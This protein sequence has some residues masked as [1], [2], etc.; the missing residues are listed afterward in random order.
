MTTTMRIDNDL[1]RESELV[2]QDIGL[3]MTN[4][5]TLFLRQVAKL[6]GIPFPL[7]CNPPQVRNDYIETSRRELLERGRKAEAFFHEAR[8]NCERD[9][10]LDEINDLIRET[11]E[12]RKD[13]SQDT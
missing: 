5:V 2:F 9:W 1:K 3:N 10:S 7:M 11:R 8:E 6:R 4:A 12:E 13:F